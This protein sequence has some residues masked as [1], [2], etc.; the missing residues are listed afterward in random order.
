MTLVRRR[1]ERAKKQRWWLVGKCS[2]HRVHL[3]SSVGL[4]PSVHSVLT[5]GRVPFS[6]DTMPKS[7]ESIF[8]FQERSEGEPNVATPTYDAIV[9]EQWTIIQV[10]ADVRHPAGAVLSHLREERIFKEVKFKGTKH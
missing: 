10:S 8:I 1:G 9:V 6:A 7:V 4:Q 3:P 2:V 5:L